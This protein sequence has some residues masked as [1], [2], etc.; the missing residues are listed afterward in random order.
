V[1]GLSTRE[2]RTRGTGAARSPQGGTDAAAPSSAR[3]L[4]QL[5]RAFPRARVLV[6]GDLMLDRFIWGDVRRISPEAPVPVVQVT[7]ESMHPGG[8]GNVVANLAALGSRARIVGWVGRDAAG[9]EIRRLLES[10]GADASG[11]L[12]SD[13]AA[14]IEKTRI[15]A[16]HQQVVR[17]DRETYRPGAHVE[18]ELAR[19]VERELPKA[20]VV[21]VSD[22]G[23]GTIHPGLLQLL[24]ECRA[25]HGF[26]Y[27]IDP[28]QPNFAHY[29]GAT[30]VKPN[31]GESAAAAGVPIDGPRELERA[32]QILLERWQSDAVL[33]SRGEHGMSLCRPGLPPRN[34]PAAAREV[35]DVTGA[36]DTVLAI[37]ALALAS[38]GSLEEASWLAN[39][40]AAVVVG[41]VGTATVGP[42]ELSEAVQEAIAGHGWWNEG[43]SRS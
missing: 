32:A 12:V 5:V 1:V 36:G 2:A 26:L 8:A 20:Q 21:I 41:K 42:A 4:L 34:F 43:R 37:A 7:R 3:R 14:S 18:R 16:H 10:L 19:R 23:K 35:F 13:A 30:L 27:L 29:R 25:R 6:V 40:G 28:K 22:Y 31:E 17:L 9:K 15:I 24:A 39:V 38:G 11:V 33:I